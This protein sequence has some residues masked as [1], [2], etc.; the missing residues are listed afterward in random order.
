MRFDDFTD[1]LMEDS[2][3]WPSMRLMSIMDSCAAAA[4]A[5]G[6]GSPG[7]RR[8]RQV[9]GSAPATGLPAATCMAT[10]REMRREHAVDQRADDERPISSAVSDRIAASMILN[11]S[12]DVETE[13]RRGRGG[14][15]DRH[16]C[17]RTAC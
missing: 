14:V 6:A 4:M 1:F 5:A 3:T 15:P 17:G 8:R 7:L 13:Q 16:R 9:A 12:P 2:R 11:Q 10:G